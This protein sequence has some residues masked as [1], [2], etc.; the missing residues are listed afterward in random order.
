MAV[1]GA[2]QAGER[3]LDA[4]AQTVSEQ[5]MGVAREQVD[6][7]R[8]AVLAKAREAG[9]GAALVGGGALL[10]G[11]ASGTG[12]AGLVLLLSG[13][14]RAAAAALGVT[15]AYAGAGAFMARDGLARLR[16]VTASSPA[17]GVEDRAPAK[18]PRPSA[19]NAAGRTKAA[20]KSPAQAARRTK[21]A[22]K[23]PTK[24]VRRREAKS[25]GP[26][27]RRPQAKRKRPPE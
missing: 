2:Q 7:A 5:A 1:P 21:G 11:L 6:V 15:G 23:S 17:P 26:S 18:P 3:S 13:R 16:E 14:P 9:P 12:T 20:A 25:T 22:A 4:L 10:A 8:R 19:A 27:S 24:S